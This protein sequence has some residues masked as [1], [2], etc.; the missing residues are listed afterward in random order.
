METYGKVRR[1]GRVTLAQPVPANADG[2]RA[3]DEK[4]A[5]ARGIPPLASSYPVAEVSGV[6]ARHEW[7]DGMWRKTVTTDSSQ[8]RSGF[9]VP[10]SESR[11][12]VVM[13]R[14]AYEVADEGL[15]DLIRRLASMSIAEA[16]TF[17]ARRYKP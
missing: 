3:L 11:H 7:I 6:Y 8:P 5:N 1:I 14:S 13:L 9:T 17:P 12:Q 4:K 2:E 16:V 10:S 15:R